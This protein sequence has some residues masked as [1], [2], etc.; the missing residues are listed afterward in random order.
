MATFLYSIY[1]GGRDSL[2]VT[3]TA[4]TDTWLTAKLCEPPLPTVG[5]T[6]CLS[7][8]EGQITSGEQTLQRLLVPRSSVQPCQVASCNRVESHR[9]IQWHDAV[10]PFILQL[11]ACKA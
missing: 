1:Y 9:I 5:S 8:D 11:A 6:D 3:V 2:V 10:E 7:L 4:V